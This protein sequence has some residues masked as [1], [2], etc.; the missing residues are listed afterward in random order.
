MCDLV[1]QVDIQKP[2]PNGR[3]F[4]TIWVPEKLA[5]IGCNFTTDMPTIKFNVWT[6]VAIYRTFLL[7]EVSNPRTERLLWKFTPV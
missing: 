5:K 7:T 6:I 2:I 1:T 4:A 3:V